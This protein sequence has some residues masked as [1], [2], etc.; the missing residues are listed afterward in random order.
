MVTRGR[1]Q[2]G[3]HLVRACE[4][5]LRRPGTDYID[6]YHMHGFD[7]LAPIEEV[8]QT[9]DQL[10]QSGKV[11]YIACSNFSG[12]HLMKSL[13][14][15]ERYGWARYV[16]HQ[17]YYSLIG[18]EF[19]CE[20]MPLGLD[21]KVGTIVRSPLGWGRLT[22][23]IRRGSRFRRRAGCTRRRNKGR[24]WTT[25]TCTRWWTP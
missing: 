10:V 16:A 18:R 19:E 21:Q 9:L 15:S 1:R 4:D 5:S 17:A 23:K 11:R 20:R 13:A 8:L 24:R 3:L 22:G 14:I 2:E 6:I 12:W 25:S 7:A